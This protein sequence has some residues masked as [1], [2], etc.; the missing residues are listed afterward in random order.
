MARPSFM[1]DHDAGTG[2]TNMIE[3]S[4]RL[5]EALVALFFEAK[6]R[7]QQIHRQWLKASVV[8]GGLLPSSLLMAELVRITSDKHEIAGDRRLKEPLELVHQPWKGE[9]TE[10]ITNIRATTICARK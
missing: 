10:I 5:G 2:N 7:Q 6:K 1:S 9:R 3:Q 4:E 8:L